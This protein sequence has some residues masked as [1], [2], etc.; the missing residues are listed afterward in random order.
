[1][2]KIPS[3]KQINLVNKM[4][5]VLNIDFPKSSR[6]FTEKKYREFINSHMSEYKNISAENILPD[7]L[8]EDCDYDVW[9]EF[10]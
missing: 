8:Y 3:V 10:Y 4:T 6:D 7:D 2:S 1:M 5:N 9:A